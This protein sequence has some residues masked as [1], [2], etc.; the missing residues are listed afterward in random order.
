MKKLIFLSLLCSVG[1]LFGQ[2][3]KAPTYL[4]VTLGSGSGA[5]QVSNSG[6]MLMAASATGTSGTSFGTP[7][8]VALAGGSV[9]MSS[10][11]AVALAGTSG[12]FGSAAFLSGTTFATAAQGIEAGTALQTGSSGVSGIVFSVNGTTLV[13][14]GSGLFPL[15]QIPAL[16]S[17]QITSGTWTLPVNASS[18][19]LSGT[20]LA[21]LFAPISLA[22]AAVQSATSATVGLTLAVSGTQ[23]TLSGSSVPW[24]VA[25]SVS[26]TS[27][28]VEPGMNGDRISFWNPRGLSYPL[29][30]VTTGTLI[31]NCD[32]SLITGTDGVYTPWL[33]LGGTSGSLTQSGTANQPVWRENGI[34]GRPAYQFSGSQWV[35]GTSITGSYGT[36]F[37]VWQPAQGNLLN[38][39]AYSHGTS[40]TA[41][42][43]D[44]LW[45]PTVYFNNGG[46]NT[47]FGDATGQNPAVRVDAV[48][49]S[50]TDAKIFKHGVFVPIVGWTATA[51]SGTET[52]IGSLITS[53]SSGGFEYSGMV[54]HVREYAG[55]LSVADVEGVSRELMAEWEPPNRGLITVMGDSIAA[56]GGAAGYWPGCILN[57]LNEPYEMRSWARG[58]QA[59]NDVLTLGQIPSEAAVYDGYNRPD[60]IA[61][62]WE[63]TNDNSQGMSGT[64]GYADTVTYS[65]SLRAMGYKTIVIG[66]LPRSGGLGEWTEANKEQFNALWRADASSGTPHADGYL[67]VEKYPL[68]GGSGAALNLSMFGDNIHPTAAACA[69]LTPELDQIIEGLTRAKKPVY[70]NG[71]NPLTLGTNCF[72]YWDFSTISG[73]EGQYVT[74]VP[75]RMGNARNTLTASGTASEPMLET[76]SA[77]GLSCLYFGGAQKLVCSSTFTNLGAFTVIVVMKDAAT[78]Y[79]GMVSENSEITLGVDSNTFLSFWGG[80]IKDSA[81]VTPQTNFSLAS[82]ESAGIE[83]S[84]ATVNIYLN[85]V[86][87][88]SVLTTSLSPGSGLNIGVAANGSSYYTGYLAAVVVLVNTGDA[89]RQGVERYLAREFNISPP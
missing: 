50:A 73:S 80:A 39:C 19:S 29:Y 43:T 62:L 88:P 66:C 49:I 28:N 33:D 32:A 27:S 7:A 79:Q 77:N 4:S 59:L 13:I 89:T 85:G 30:P 86:L 45:P 67:D 25:S 26:T 9:A 55:A 15:A 56:G 63:Y 42:F 40:G 72:A 36:F 87:S 38:E 57:G 75:D 35:T 41:D 18:I 70:D 21:A 46:E 20:A 11:A 3:Y 65:G 58:G 16:P 10:T 52:M 51:I 23:L 61:I 82:F 24:A 68:I 64:T 83:G 17:S 14:S 6:G 44:N 34:N 8:P 54:G 71:I 12:S 1:S 78:G 76:G 48:Q 81:F 69:V 2:S 31:R 84:N 74:S 37:I 5:L 60:K 22:S 47:F 53:P